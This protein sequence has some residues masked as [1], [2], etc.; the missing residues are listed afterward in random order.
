M[1]YTSLGRTGLNVSRIG[2]G[3]NAVGGHNLFNSL[4]ENEGIRMVETAL[5]LGIN[6]IDTADVYGFGRSEELI[7]QVLSSMKHKR[8]QIVLATKGARQ[9]MEDG[10]VRT[11]NDPKYLRA[12]LEASLKRLRTDYVDLYYIHY[13]DGVTPLAESIGELGRLREEGKIKEIGISN[14]NLAQLQEADATGLVSVLQAPYNMLEREAEQDL[15]PYCVEHRI[16]FV[17]YGPL[18]YGILGGRYDANFTLTEGD[19]RLRVSLFKPDT[20]PRILKKV[21]RLK[22]IA[23]E[24]NAELP[25]LALAWLL[26]QP[27]IDAVIPGGKRPDQAAA[28]AKADDVMLTQEHLSR[29]QAILDDTGE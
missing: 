19:W 26:A 3:T 25:A 12:A 29:I 7:G 27:G 4:D 21:D 11:N 1:R 22:Q 14:V 28:N 9:R 5:E 20:Y 8:D 18:A 15:L 23:A 24:V 6:F 2:L 13:P 10:T 16:S 17:P